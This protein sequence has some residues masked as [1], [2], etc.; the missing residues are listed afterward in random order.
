[1]KARHNRLA[2]RS[3]LLIGLGV[4]AICVAPTAAFSAE[5]LNDGG[6]EA[7]TCDATECTDSSWTQSV[8]TAFSN[9]TG[10]IC[11]SG[12]GT[13][14]TDCSG[15]GSA[16]FSGST[17]ARFGAGYKASA[18]FGGGVISSLQ[19]TVPIPTAP[20]TL[21]FRLRIINT[22]GPTGEFTVEAGGAQVFATTDTTPGFVSY[23]PVTIDLS[24]LGGTTPLLKFEGTSS[25]GP[26]GALDSFDVDDISLTTV[27]PSV[28]TVDPRCVNLRAKLKKAKSK[29]KKRKVR[30]R[31][32]ALGC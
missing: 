21:S 9:A 15:G 24:S 8:T 10:P 20:A 2:W 29:K 12:T 19:Q 7:S 31:I 1:M 16:P 26:V 13:G 17:W 22:A 25:Q 14:N 4:A 18:M 3:W 5:R 11:R 30:K 6:F 28:A 23:A 32:Q 27:D